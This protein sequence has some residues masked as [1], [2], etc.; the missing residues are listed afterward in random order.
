MVSRVREFC[1]RTAFFV[2]GLFSILIARMYRVLDMFFPASR[3]AWTAIACVLMIVGVIN[4]VA[5]IAPQPWMR[6]IFGSIEKQWLKL[7]FKMLAGFLVTSNV[8]VVVLSLLPPGTVVPPVT[9]YILCPSCVSTIT[10][11]PSLTATLLLLAPMSAAAYG[12][13][14]AVIGIRHW[15][16]SR[17]SETQ[18][19]RCATLC[20]AWFVAYPEVTVIWL[21]VTSELPV[22]RPR[23][24]QIGSKLGRSRT[25]LGDCMGLCISLQ[26]ESDKQIEFVADEKNLL[27]RLIGYPDPNEFPMLASIDRYGNTIFNRVQ[28][29]RFL[30]EWKT[31]FRSANTPDEI[32]LL[33][34]V[35][36]FAE[37]SIHGVHLYLVF[38]GD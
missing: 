1:V 35:K 38:I 31:L 8:V 14:G 20:S 16:I 25:I 17:K 28:M 37:K 9:V 23:F 18:S 7:P 27:D 11:D 33:N 21:R 36:D 6:P 2:C 4:A 19:I 29:D 3:H 13:I 12:S 22:N 10:V 15:R 26:K 5:A 24:S 32:A 34:V 30:A